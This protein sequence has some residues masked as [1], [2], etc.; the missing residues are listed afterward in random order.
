M[1]STPP[2]IFKRKAKPAPRTRQSSPEN[3][4]E[5]GTTPAV[6]DSPSTLAARLKNKAKKSQPKSRLSFGG[7]EEESGGDVFQVKKSNLSRK[8]ALGKNAASIPLNLDQATISSHGPTYDQA[9]LQQLKASTP[10]SRPV[11]ANDAYDVDMSIDIESAPTMSVDTMDPLGSEAIIPS[12]SSIKIARE[13][14]ERLRKTGLSGEEE[15]ISLSVVRKSEEQGPHPESRLVREEDELG[16]GD[17]EFAEYT[18]AQERIALG[19]KSRK[20]EAG[21][22]RDVMKE[23]IADAEDEDEETAEWE[24][25]QL[26]R[27]G[28][29]TPDSRPSTPKVKQTYKPAPIPVSIPIPTLGPAMNRLA[30]QLTQ[31]TTSHTSNTTSLDALT[32]EQGEVDDR[33]KEM[34]EMVAR[35]EDKRAWFDSFKEWIEGVAG[36]LDEKYPSLEKLEEEHTSLLRE[37]FA[38]ITRRRH[39]DDEDDLTIVLGTQ[40]TQPPV[41]TET[42][43]ETDELG[44]ATPKLSLAVLRR[45]RRDARMRRHQLR[46]PQKTT[47]E[48]GYSTDGSLPAPEASDYSTALK[49]LATRTKDVLADVRAEEFRDPGKGRWNAWREKYTD[50]YVGAWG[51]LGVVS[52]WEFWV[53]LEMVGWDCIEDPRSLDSFKWYKGLY[54]YSRPGDSEGENGELGPDGDLVASMISTA[55][56]PRLCA[57]IAE[58]F[59]PYSEKHIRRMIDLTEEVEASVEEG[60]AKLQMLTKS[61]AVSFQTAIAHTEALLSRYMSVHR[62]ASSFNPETIPARRRFLTRRVKLFLNLLRWRKQFGE[63]FGVGLMAERLI[64]RCILIVAEGGWEVGGEEITRKVAAM[65]PNDIAVP[66]LKRR[67]STR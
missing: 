49:S 14:R 41:E 3:G 32:R 4:G 21:K 58:T 63:R 36:F 22:R 9:H 59:D 43:T 51:G 54:T 6:D 27:G 16:E 29:R 38:I 12:E 66:A 15:F 39:A 7:D 35:A 25:E 17:D 5:A 24:Q 56:I 1:A 47:E 20:L 64:E 19:K 60:N 10:T 11:A 18:S 28:H 44:H 48:E 42:E 67:L 37:R 57:V 52:V 26:R 45:E 62:G 53:R 30:A 40:S 55:V 33:E 2:I 13:K 50:S 8:L 61:V 65:L 31:L 23:M 34:R 46:K